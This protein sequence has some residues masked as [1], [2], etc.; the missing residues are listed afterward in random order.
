M[1][2]S[3][4]GRLGLV[5]VVMICAIAATT[6]ALTHHGGSATDSTPSSRG[7]PTPQPAAPKVRW[8]QLAGVSLP[9]STT[10]G[11]HDLSNGLARGFSDTPDG[12]A[13]AAV[14]LVV[15]TSPSVS[16]AIVNTTLQQQVVGP[17]QPALLRSVSDARS[18][19]APAATARVAGYIPVYFDPSR[20][21]SVDLVIGSPE[22]AL[23]R[24]YLSVRV[25]LQWSDDDWRLVA[26]PQG[27]WATVTSTIDGLPVGMHRYGG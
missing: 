14:H 12:A 15:R 7:T 1:S 20:S 5:A 4:A 26:P 2:R 18:V 19:H 24:Q 10:D 27:D 22:L 6:L 9:V 23:R 3:R 16:P 8:V 13:L 25:S 17:N 11:P 21:A